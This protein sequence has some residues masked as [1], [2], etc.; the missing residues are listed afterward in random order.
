M[1]R[2]LRRRRYCAVSIRPVLSVLLLFLVIVL[3]WHNEVSNRK[4]TTNGEPEHEV[5]GEKEKAEHK[6][7]EQYK[8]QLHDQ[9]SLNDMFLLRAQEILNGNQNIGENLDVQL[10]IIWKDAHMYRRAILHDIEKSFLVLDLAEFDWG[11]PPKEFDRFLENLW[12]LYSGKGGWKKDGMVKKVRQCG[13]GKFIA[14]IVADMNPRY[15]KKRTAHG[16][17]TVSVVMHRKKN[18]Y[19]EWSGGGFRVH[20]TFSTQEAN[21]DIRVLFHKTLEDVL[22]SAVERHVYTHSLVSKYLDNPTHFATTQVVYGSTHTQNGLLQEHVEEEQ[23]KQNQQKHGTWQCTSFLFALGSLTQVRVTDWETNAMLW[24]R[25]SSSVGRPLAV[26]EEKVMSCT[27]W[28]KNLSI[29]VPTLEI[30]GLIA[31]LRAKPM[32]LETVTLDSVFTIEL[33]GSL[34]VLKFKVYN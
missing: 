32:P 16:I 28:P 7:Q 12:V 18:L 23:K 13:F 1:R 2:R 14:V 6:D 29:Y 19:R 15:A 20:G 33:E 8:Q 17:D 11:S 22:Q 30:W 21:H 26:E 3:V 5:N 10:F 25:R 24:S 34:R 4:G 9:S 27:L 31:L